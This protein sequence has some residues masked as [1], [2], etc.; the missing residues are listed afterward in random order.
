MLPGAVVILATGLYAARYW[1]AWDRFVEGAADEAI[2]IAL[3]QRWSDPGLFAADPALPALAQFAPPAYVW[4][5][6]LGVRAFGPGE[7]LLVASTVL[8][9]VYAAG[10]Y[11]L[12]HLVTGHRWAAA[13]VA[14]VA[15][16]PNESLAI[17]WGVYLGSA[18]P[19]SFVVALIP[20]LVAFWLGARRE[21]A[22]LLVLGVVIGLVG[23]VHPITGLHLALV[24]AGALLIDGGTAW[25]LRS[26]AAASVV[27]GFAAGITPYVVQ[28]LVRFDP[29]PFDMALIVERVGTQVF[30]SLGAVA[31]TF[32]F[33][34]A[35]PIALAVVG[36]RAA[37]T[38]EQRAAATAMAHLG[39]VAIVLT[40]L[41]PIQAWLVPRWFAVHLV[42][43][44]GYVFLFALVLAGV[45]LA[46]LLRAPRMTVR[47]AAVMLGVALFA[48]AGGARLPQLRS[49]ATGEARTAGALWADVRRA[50]I[51]I[52]DKRAFLDLCA[53]A[54]A[55]TERDALFAAPPGMFASF[56][57]Y[58]RRP[59]F[60]TFKD[61]ALLLNFSGTLGR[62]WRARFDAN[63]RLYASDRGD[64]I[65]AVARDHGIRYVIRERTTPPVG[66]PVAFENAVYRVYVVERAVSGT[67]RPRLAGRAPH[68]GARA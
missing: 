55:A 9:V 44:S 59:L 15:L 42:R 18:P 65:V 51:G 19:R 37:T 43:I 63:D 50:G 36:W 3:A 24:L 11:R 12:A 46:R 62:A 40:A 7:F 53:W 28:L 27:G 26:L 57:V 6:A 31:G 21:P 35:M 58:A 20:W 14:I 48:T 30:P 5:T 38:P 56:R 2:W 39:L 25:R 52:P 13:L 34:Y 45:L 49:A 22:R 32:V 41:G 23:N 16:R 60:V 29:S 10:V 67:T 61:G 66:L 54:R 64:A 4:L 47:V 68:P 8:L 33:S 1:L 17:G